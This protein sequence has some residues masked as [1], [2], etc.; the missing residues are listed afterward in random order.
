MQQITTARAIVEAPGF[1]PGEYSVR[2][3]GLQPQPNDAPP[4]GTSSE[5]AKYASPGRKSGVPLDGGAPFLAGLARSG[6]W[7]AARSR[8][9]YAA[10]IVIFSTSQSLIRTAPASP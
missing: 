3:D 9:F 4:S 2:Y 6:A 5:G 7:K 10:R 8:H 1:Q